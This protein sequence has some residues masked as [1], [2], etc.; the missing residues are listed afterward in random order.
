MG[1]VGRAEG[2]ATHAVA[3]L[4]EGWCGT[5]EGADDEPPKWQRAPSAQGAGRT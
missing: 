4:E 3:L 5:E 1:F 2:I